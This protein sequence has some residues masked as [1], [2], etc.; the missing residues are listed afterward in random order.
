MSEEEYI[1]VIPA[2]KKNKDMQGRLAR[3]YISDILPKDEGK[4][5][6]I[7]ASDIKLNIPLEPKFGI[8][9]NTLPF[10]P[11]QYWGFRKWVKSTTQNVVISNSSVWIIALSLR[12]N[13]GIV[14]ICG[15]GLENEKTKWSSSWW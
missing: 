10:T 11:V 2:T 6:I 7:K 14:G 13:A 4:T 3:I 8:H 9:K 12:E 1:I 5:Y 15:K